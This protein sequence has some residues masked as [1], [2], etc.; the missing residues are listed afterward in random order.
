MASAAPQ[1]QTSADQ[2]QMSY[3]PTTPMFP[4]SDS[5]PSSQPWSNGAETM[6][7]LG[8]Y[9]PEHNPSQ[10][11]GEHTIDTVD[12]HVQLT[13]TLPLCVHCLH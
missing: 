10:H 2:Y 9:T 11:S 5:M 6:T 1:T 3:Y 12:S 4:Y 7:F 8:G 13:L